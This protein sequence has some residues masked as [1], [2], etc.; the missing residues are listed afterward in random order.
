MAVTKASDLTDS[1]REQ[2]EVAFFMQNQ[3]MLVYD[4]LVTHDL[5]VDGVSTNLP[6]Y[7]KLAVATTPLTDGSITASTTLT[8]TPHIITPVEYGIVTQPSKLSELV[9]SNKSRVAAGRAVAM[10][11]AETQNVQGYTALA[12]STNIILA[13]DAASVA[14]I[15][16]NDTVQDRD[17]KDAVA[18]LAALNA[19]R[20]PFTLGEGSKPAYAGG[21]HPYV[22]DDIRSLTGFIDAM[23]YADAMR[24]ITGEIGTYAGVRFFETTGNVASADAGAGA[25]DVYTTVIFALGALGKGTS[26]APHLIVKPNGADG[27]NRTVFVSWYGVYEYGII[28]QSSLY[29]IKSAASLGANV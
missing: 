7:G 18:E 2:M 1:Q 4:D 13:N 23:K 28:N 8:D 5:G 15:D 16:E 21:V 10:N 20:F 22:A 14:A 11:A 12:A 29:A 25:V 9:T 3:Q 26:L 6:E 27:Q 19:M 17:I 24:L